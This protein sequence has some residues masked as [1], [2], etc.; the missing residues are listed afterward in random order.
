MVKFSKDFC[1]KYTL[2]VT[3]DMAQSMNNLEKE[4]VALQM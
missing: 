1:Q 4:I 3:R 2:N